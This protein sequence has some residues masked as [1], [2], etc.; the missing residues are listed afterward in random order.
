M[1]TRPKL[2][3]SFWFS[4][5]VYPLSITFDCDQ[6]PLT[7]DRVPFEFIQ[8]PDPQ[9]VGPDEGYE[10]TLIS[11]FSAHGDGMKRQCLCRSHRC[12]SPPHQNG[13]GRNYYYHCRNW[14]LGW[15]RTPLLLW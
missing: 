15:N 8:F 11:M 6:P 1:C 3:Y 4:L 14:F 5:G 12:R 10:C 2:I 13:T 7:F 9:V